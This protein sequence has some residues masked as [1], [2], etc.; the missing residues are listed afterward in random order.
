MYGFEEFGQELWY[1]NM[2]MNMIKYSLP[3]TVSIFSDF[4]LNGQNW[5]FKM[6]MH[7]FL[8]MMMVN[9]FSSLFQII[10]HVEKQVI[11]CYN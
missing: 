3:V 2:E 6:G 1:L 4:F 8:I 11:F 9:F 10:V 5:L 7:L